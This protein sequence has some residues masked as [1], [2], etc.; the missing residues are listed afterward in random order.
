MGRCILGS[1][2]PAMKISVE[3]EGRFWSSAL[4]FTIRTCSSG[5]LVHMN[6]SALHSFERW[7]P[8]A[9]DCFLCGCFC[10]RYKFTNHIFKL[11]LNYVMPCICFLY[12]FISE[13][14]NSSVWLTKLFLTNKIICVKTAIICILYIWNIHIFLWSSKK[15]ISIFETIFYF[16]FYQNFVF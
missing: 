7:S 8:A 3:T 13:V 4:G 2:I 1:K 9:I 10:V 16:S 6:I 15:K 12:I 11:L 5:R 14:R